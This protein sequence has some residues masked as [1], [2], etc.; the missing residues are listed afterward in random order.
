MY[1]LRWLVD[2]FFLESIGLAYDSVMN[3]LKNSWVGDAEPPLARFE[4]LIVKVAFPMND[5]SPLPF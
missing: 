1:P 5:K 2:R 3:T 4:N